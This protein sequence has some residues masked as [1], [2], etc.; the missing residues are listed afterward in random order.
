MPACRTCK[1]DTF[2]QI[3]RTLSHVTHDWDFSGPN[4]LVVRPTHEAFHDFRM[5]RRVYLQL[6]VT[7]EFPASPVT[8]HGRSSDLSAG[9]VGA[10]IRT[11]LP[12]A[13][14][15]GIVRISRPGGQK[16]I[17]LHA[18][19]RYQSGLRY[20]FEFTNVKA[21]DREA[22]RRLIENRKRRAADVA[23]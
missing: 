19:L 10:V 22:I 8:I 15:S 14:K 23:G 16:D 9:G 13:A 3:V 2:F 20:G 7:V 5:F 17:A 6:P 11:K 4:N 1:L 21:A 18:Q 12:A